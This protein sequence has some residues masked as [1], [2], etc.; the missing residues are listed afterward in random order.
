MTEGPLTSTVGHWQCQIDSDGNVY[1]RKC[2]LHDIIHKFYE[3]VTL[4]NDI[5]R[6]NVI[7]NSLQIA[8]TKKCMYGFQ[9]MNYLSI[10]ISFK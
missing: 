7:I 4:M 2:R 8:A 3:L 10:I 5:K 6:I 9:R 1:I